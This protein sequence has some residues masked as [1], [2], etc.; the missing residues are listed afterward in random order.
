MPRRLK[1]IYIIS[2]FTS[3]ADLGLHPDPAWKVSSS[4]LLGQSIVMVAFTFT[5]LALLALQTLSVLAADEVTAD[6]LAEGV[7]GS[8]KLAT[9]A[10]FPQSEI[11]G[12]KLVNGH[13]TQCVIDV[14]NNELE[15]VTV[16][17]VGGS[18]NTINGPDQ[19]VRNLTM[20]RPGVQIPAGEKQSIT[21]SFATE[22]HP[23]DLRL[24]LTSVVQDSKDGI[25]IVQVY[26][27]TV[28]VVEAPTSI[29][30]PQI[31]FL[32]IVLAAAFSGTCYFIYS[33]WFATLF[34]QKRRGGK[35]GERAK[36]SSNGSKKVD[37]TDQ[38]SVVGA[39]GPAVTSGSKVYDESWIPASHLQ[40][41]EARRI[42]SG[43]ST[44][45]TKRAA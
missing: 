10:R 29:F 4:H 35:G 42:G 32:Y 33:T 9:V 34:P 12:V 43:R 11:F 15:P 8:I 31:I 2:S 16:L 19:I 39:D 36:Y 17:L 26:N 25:H 22:L 18:L 1:A 14:Q 40:R 5:S 20:Q 45:K 7:E 37:P 27:E 44:P 13:P 30:D 41:P 21:Y 23:Q 6:T 38:A 24:H 3:F 28:S